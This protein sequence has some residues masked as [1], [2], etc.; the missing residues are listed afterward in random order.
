MTSRLAGRTALVTGGSSGIGRAV[1]LRFAAEGA[2][3]LVCDIREAPVWD[4]IDQRP[5]ADI[6]AATGGSAEF[7]HTDVSDEYAVANAF[8]QAMNFTGRVDVAVANAALLDA[9]TVEETTTADWDRI[10]DVNL[11]GQYHVAREAVTVMSGQ[12]PI[13][14][15]RGRLI[16]VASQFGLVAPPGSF[17][18]AVAKGGVVQM[19]RQ[20]AVDYG[21][22]GVIV[23]SVA[24]G[25]ILTRATDEEEA[26]STDPSLPYSLS[27]TPF[28]RLGRPEDV[29]GAALFLASDDCTFISGHVLSVDGGW[30]A[31]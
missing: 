27:R 16:T 8:N 13:Q 15:T 17:A 12:E 11:R 10:M 5:T 24:P 25:K 23:N 21:E 26:A 3:V 22:Q 1:A 20:L 4:G 28:H 6:I 9:L 29:A 31:S 2:H 18:Y 7:C 30:T 14:E 19:T